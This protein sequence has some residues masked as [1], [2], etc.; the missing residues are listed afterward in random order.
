MSVPSVS[1]RV[2]EVVPHESE[3][4]RAVEAYRSAYQARDVERMLAL[5]TEDAEVTIAPGTFLGRDAIRKLFDWDARLSPT[6][7]VRDAGIGVLVSGR[8]VVW[9]HV[10][11]LTYESIP[12]DEEATKVFEF[13]DGGKIRRLRSYYDKLAIM[14]QIASRY[15]GIQ[16]WIFKKL[17]G[18]LVTQGSKDLDATPT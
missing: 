12:Y 11:S 13:D 7:K 3:L 10:V 15:P 2:F 17:T 5:F 6:A 9:E 18:Y 16:G 8:T 1:A 14:D 4:R